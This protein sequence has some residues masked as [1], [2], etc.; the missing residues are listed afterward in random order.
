MNRSDEA[1]KAY[2]DWLFE[3]TKARLE[4]YK[5]RS[6]LDSF[7]QELL[8]NKELN[9]TQ[10]RDFLKKAHFTHIEKLDAH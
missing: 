1:A 3:C 7:A 8:T 2:L 9:E 6:L 5:S 10:V 4:F